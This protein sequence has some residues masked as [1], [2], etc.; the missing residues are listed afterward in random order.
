MRASKV[1]INLIHEAGGTPDSTATAIV[2]DRIPHAHLASVPPPQLR[3]PEV[4]I[5]SA[6]PM[7]V[8]T[9]Y[10]LW[11]PVVALRT[12]LLL[13]LL[14]FGVEVPIGNRWSVGADYY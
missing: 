3:L 14:N 8:D 1:R 2:P 7:T 4:I 13:P 11:K 10:K 6:I 5:P 9:S 12:N